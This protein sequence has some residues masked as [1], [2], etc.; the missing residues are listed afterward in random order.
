MCWPDRPNRSSTFG[1]LVAVADR[2]DHGHKL[3]REPPT[4]G[5]HD[6]CRA[7]LISRSGAGFLRVAGGSRC[8]G[9]SCRPG[10]LGSPVFA[11][12][13]C[14]SV[15]RGRIRDAGALT[16]VPIHLG[17]DGASATA[18][19]LRTL[20][21]VIGLSNRL[22]PGRC[23]QWPDGSVSKIFPVAGMVALM[24]VAKSQMDVSGRHR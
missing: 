12:V 2:F 7:K 11:A 5:A 15:L 13:C 20:P 9:Q 3:G 1:I 17:Y 16:F 6:H 8:C 22:A 10:C 21:M 4:P 24:A 19:G 14:V 18:S 23:L